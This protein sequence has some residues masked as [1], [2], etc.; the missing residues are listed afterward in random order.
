[1][2]SATKLVRVK[3]FLALV[4]AVFGASAIAPAR[5]DETVRAVWNVQEI[6]LPYF[7]ITTYYS[8]DGL[9]DR[10]RDLLGQLGVRE[11]FIVTAVGCTELSAPSRT[12]TAR[13]IVA[14]AVPAT[15]EVAKAFATDPKRAELLARLQKKSKAPMS[16]EPFDAFTKRVTLRA[17][18]KHSTGVGA[19]G[20]CELLEQMHRFVF[21]KIGAKVINDDVSCMPHQ[22]SVGNPSIEVELLVAVPA[23]KP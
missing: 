21:P 14:N 5:A 18:D 1:M 4:C 3:T 16:D 6:Y 2:L 9:R 8:C 15:D 20:D 7:G 11:D 12:P 13:I 17:K 10:V 19:S 22:G 23:A